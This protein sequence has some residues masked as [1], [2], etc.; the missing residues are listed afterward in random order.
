MT[1]QGLPVMTNKDKQLVRLLQLI[2]KIAHDQMSE[3]TPG[4]Y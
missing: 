3:Q 2:K 1:R 4:S